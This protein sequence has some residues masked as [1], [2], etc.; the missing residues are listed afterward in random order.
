MPMRSYLYNSSR[1]NGLH[2]MQ[3]RVD[4][5]RTGA[6][7]LLK[8]GYALLLFM[9]S[10]A[11]LPVAAQTTQQWKA[12]SVTNPHGANG[13]VTT[14]DLIT[15]TLNVKNTGASP[16]ATITMVDTIPSTTVLVTAPNATVTT[17]GG[18]TIATWTYTNVPAGT[19]ESENIIAKVGTNLTGVSYIYNT[20]YVNNGNGSGFQPTGSA[21][22]SDPNTPG[23]NNGWPSTQ[24]EVDNGSNGVAWMSYALQ[25]ADENG[26]VVAATTIINYTIHIRNTG[27]TALTNV[28]VTDYVPAYSTFIDADG[29]VTPDGTNKLQWTVPSIATG[30]DYIIQFRARVAA[31]LTGATSIDNTASVD[32]GNGKGAK[33]TYPSISG[34]A[35]NP[36]TAVTIG[37]STSIP[38]ISV[39]TF[40]TWELAVDDNGAPITKVTPGTVIHFIIYVR[41]TGNVTIPLL[42]VNTV[43]PQGTEHLDQQDGGEYNSSSFTFTWKIENLAASQVA[44]VHY[45]LTVTGGQGLNQIVSTAV[46]RTQD[47][48]VNSTHCDPEDASCDK[49]EGTTIALAGSAPGFFVTNVVTPNGD[50]KNDF[51]VVSNPKATATTLVKLYVFNRWGGT[52]YESDNYQNGWDAK[53]LSEGTY[54]YRLEVS[55]SAAAAA[56]QVLKGWVMIIR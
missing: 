27:S 16:I 32:L 30:A 23:A 22:A 35:G 31:D 54:F 36:N 20:A 51:F 17:S 45:Q 49:K 11:C 2:L 6:T 47:T 29:G 26:N 8:S 3:Q 44:T 25:N 38:I 41:N 21:S 55:D 24:V 13:A 4:L 52:V 28:I 53:G 56:P 18:Y 34:D 48:S 19:T 46:G 7:K 12:V 40:E 14:N 5:V 10:L 37:P 50:G 1:S 15:Y 43:A 39:S 42:F 9:A 33:N